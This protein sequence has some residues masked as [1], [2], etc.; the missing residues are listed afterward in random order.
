MRQT[1]SRSS[2]PISI[3]IEKALTE[4]G[5]RFSHFA[6]GSCV[7]AFHFASNLETP[8]SA[9]AGAGEARPSPTEKVCLRR[10]DKRKAFGSLLFLP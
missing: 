4:S 5:T 7:P 8:R 1:K 9:L 3:A 10:P 2:V 6:F